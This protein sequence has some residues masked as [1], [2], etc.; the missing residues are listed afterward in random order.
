MSSD[1]SPSAP[2]TGDT[3][4]SSTSAT[5]AVPPKDSLSASASAYLKAIKTEVNVSQH[6]SYYRQDFGVELDLEVSAVM[7][8]PF[9][10]MST[11]Y[12]LA[13]LLQIAQSGSDSEFGETGRFSEATWN[14]IMMDLG[15]SKELCKDVFE[16]TIF[17]YHDIRKLEKWVATKWVFGFEVDVTT[18]AIWTTKDRA[19]AW[20]VLRI[21]GFF[22]P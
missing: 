5:I 7:S 12:M 3:P 16:S 20:E 13:Y 10:D 14:G 4:P 9:D 17:T 11:T 6:S 8:R 19:E 22:S 15:R 18:G 1:M 2:P 21:V